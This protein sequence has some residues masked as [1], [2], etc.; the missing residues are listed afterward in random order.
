[1]CVLYICV[2]VCVYEAQ[3][4]HGHAYCFDIKMS[5]IYVTFYIAAT[6]Q[7]LYRGYEN[8]F[9][10]VIFI[11]SYTCRYVLDFAM[12]KFSTN[13]FVR[14]MKEETHICINCYILLIFIFCMFWYFSYNRE[15]FLKCLNIEINMIRCVLTQFGIFIN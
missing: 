7:S 6:I 13:V 3:T 5:K 14:S 15:D 4:L 12:I 11:L 2:Y 8:F 9:I 10:F 1:M